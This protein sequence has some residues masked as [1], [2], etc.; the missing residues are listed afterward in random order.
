MFLINARAGMH[1]FWL[2]PKQVVQSRRPRPV[3][4]RFESVRIFCRVDEHNPVLVEESPITFDNNLEILPILEV[5]PC[6]TVAERVAVHG[7][8][9]IEG[10]TH[11]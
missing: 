4:N 3:A 11:S 6:P 1:P 5:E 2:E 8:G 9:R 7:R 10:G